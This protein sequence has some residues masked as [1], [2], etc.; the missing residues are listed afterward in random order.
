MGC[1]ELKENNQGE[2]NKYAGDSEILTKEN[3]VKYNS[4]KLMSI[5][6]QCSNK[7]YSLENTKFYRNYVNC[8]MVKN[9]NLVFH[10]LDDN[11]NS[12]GTCNS[13]SIYKNAKGF[14]LTYQ[15]LCIETDK[16]I[17]NH[18]IST[19]Y[20][21]PYLNNN[22]NNNP[23]DDLIELIF[24]NM[25]HDDEKKYKLYDN[26]DDELVSKND[27]IKKYTE[28]LKEIAKKENININIYFSNTNK[29]YNYCYCKENNEKWMVFKNASEI[30]KELTDEVLETQQG[31]VELFQTVRIGEINAEGGLAVVEETEDILKAES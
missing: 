11:R 2:E 26:Q 29:I 14:R 9:R 6:V 22:L 3:N 10:Y 21:G 17:K 23:T 27:I 5:Y 20:F 1:N 28:N 8:S 30:D 7:D 31:P 13:G 12:R 15:D 19:S 18:D 25:Q 24:I 4:D 16:V